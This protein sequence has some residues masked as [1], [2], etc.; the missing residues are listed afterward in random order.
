[1]AILR[2]VLP[3]SAN[4][5]FLAMRRH[6]F[7]EKKVDVT[8]VCEWIGLVQDFVDVERGNEGSS[9]IRH[10][11]IGSFLV[12]RNLRQNRRLDEVFG[13]F[14]LV[15]RVYQLATRIN[16]SRRH[17][18]NQV[19][20]DVLF[21]VRAKEAA[22][23]WNVTQE[24]SAI[25]CLLHVFTHETPQHNCLAIPDA[26]AGRDLACAEDGLVDDVWREDALGRAD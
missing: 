8:T 14:S 4:Q 16:Q 17:E 9:N 15:I 20:F 1:M 10:D 22:D 6:A 3:T 13:L 7:R 24:R 19:S 21:R 25:L 11:V 5:M 18:D 23:D 2:A 26:H 12:K